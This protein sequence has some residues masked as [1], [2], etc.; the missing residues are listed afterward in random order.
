MFVFALEVLHVTQRIPAYCSLQSKTPG[1]NLTKFRLPC[2]FYQLQNN[3][4]KKKFLHGCSIPQLYIVDSNLMEVL[5]LV[6]A[7][8]LM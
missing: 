4:T 3:L 1:S 2:V 5:S 7:K 8:R 6:C